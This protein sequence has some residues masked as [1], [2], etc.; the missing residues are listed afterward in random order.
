M[1][2]D[3]MLLFAEEKKYYTTWPF[4][5]MD[6]IEDVIVPDS[7]GENEDYILYLGNYELHIQNGKKWL[8]MR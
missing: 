5:R 8:L 7:N 6:S 3:G 2:G 4:G 1:K